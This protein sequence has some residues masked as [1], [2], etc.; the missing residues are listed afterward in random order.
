MIHDEMIV[1][2]SSIR[3]YHARLLS[4]NVGGTERSYSQASAV[5]ILRLPA[6]YHTTL[7]S[8]QLTITL[9]FFPVTATE[10]SRG[11]SIP[12]RLSRSTDNIVRF[13]SDISNKVLEIAL[14]DGYVYKAFL[15][16]CGTPSFDATGEQDIEY[17]FLAIRTKLPVKKVI[18]AGE[19]I[20]CES[21]TTTPFRLSLT[22]PSTVGSITICGIIIRSITA[23]TEIV[24]DSELGLVTANGVNKFNDTELIDFPYLTPGNNTISCTVANAEIT[25]VYTPI[26]A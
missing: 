10:N 18:T 26:Y 24:I 25:V 1:N 6:V 11:T 4:Y 9:T 12:E 20:Y 14:P 8:R 23:G 21:N 15:Q 3:Q 5:G 13:E 22:V 2:G 17:N 19:S 7:S 16:S